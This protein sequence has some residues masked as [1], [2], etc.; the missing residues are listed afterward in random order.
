MTVEELVAC[1]F[2]W[3]RKKAFKYCCDTNDAEDLAGETIYKCLKNGI[4]FDCSRSFRPWVQVI[5][6]NTFKTFYNRRKSILFSSYE[7][8]LPLPCHDLADERIIMRQAF[9]IIKECSRKSTCLR[10]VMLYAK[11]YS[12]EEISLIEEIPVGTVRSRISAGRKLLKD[13][14]NL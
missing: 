4:R 14:L 5:M 3:I 12:Y 7:E 8:A 10:A 1:N 13:E 9:S 6:E 11:G 2:D